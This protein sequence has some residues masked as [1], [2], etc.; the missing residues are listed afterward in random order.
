MHNIGQQLKEAR[1]A[2]GLT[3][4][5][6][7]ERTMIPIKYLTALE[8][9]QFALFPGE[10]YLKGALRKYAA[11]LGLDAQ[12]LV[13]SYNEAA[14]ETIVTEN[15]AA[16]M[17]PEKKPPQ[18]PKMELTAVLSTI[19]LKR[20]LP[21]VAV[22][23]LLLAGS[24]LISKW[25]AKTPSQT[26]PPPANEQQNEEEPG[27]TDTENPEANEEEPAVLVERDPSTENVHFIVR[28]ADELT[29]ELSFSRPCWVRAFSDGE[30]SLDGT[31]R[32]GQPQV[33][34][35][36][37]EISIRIGNPPAVS[38]TI[39]GQTVELPETKYA[40]TLTISKE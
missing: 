15:R 1:E 35:A 17:P 8:T 33:A 39:N 16:V 10:V 21:L 2:Q 38:L 37:E 20:F 18:K 40:Y 22:I 3:L 4:A 25:S 31:F 27:P 28:H 11:E 26:D 6:I 36:A 12:A 9:E 32:P 30:K 29:A 19:Q 23:L 7:T 13:D 24:F 34:R 5:E 14:A